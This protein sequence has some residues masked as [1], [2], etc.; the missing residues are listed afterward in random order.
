MEPHNQTVMLGGY[1]AGKSSILASILYSLSEETK[2]D[3]FTVS[4]DTE[5][6]EK[7]M[8][9]VSMSDDSMRMIQN[10]KHD[11]YRYSWSTIKNKLFNA[12][13]L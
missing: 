12:Y 7:M 1:R 4:D 11:L 10:A 2:G 9:A 5:M 8:K 3:I 13:N 6:A